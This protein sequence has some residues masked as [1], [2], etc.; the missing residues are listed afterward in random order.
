MML[1]TAPV[2]PITATVSNT[3][4]PRFLFEIYRTVGRSHDHGHRRT[5]CRSRRPDRKALTARRLLRWARR[6][7][8]VHRDR[9]W[10]RLTRT[11]IIIP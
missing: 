3:L 11:A 2:A 4:I 5:L 10:P 1:P 8:Q 7:P 9:A 6:L